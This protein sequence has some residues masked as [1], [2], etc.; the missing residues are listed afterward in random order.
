MYIIL[1]A[2][3]SATIRI[4]AD[5]G[6]SYGGGGGGAQSQIWLQ[7][8]LVYLE[9]RLVLKNKSPRMLNI[10]EISCIVHWRLE[11]QLVICLKESCVD[12]GNRFV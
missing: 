3:T 7:R 4:R 9:V 5:N 11:S 10:F 2:R 12:I 1:I 6:R 8:I